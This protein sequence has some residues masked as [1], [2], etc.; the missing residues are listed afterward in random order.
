MPRST[1][2]TLLLHATA[3][4]D[5]NDDPWTEYKKWY[6]ECPHVRRREAGAGSAPTGSSAAS[7]AS[8]GVLSGGL[9]GL[10]SFFSSGSQPVHV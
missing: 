4:Q 2:F 8:S 10:K 5:A 3:T 9:K 7:V 6:P 1:R